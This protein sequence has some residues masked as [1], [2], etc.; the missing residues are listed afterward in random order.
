MSETTR[1]GSVNRKTSN[2]RD[3]S[4]DR[5]LREKVRE[6]KARGNTYGKR[7]SPPVMVRGDIGGP[8]LPLRKTTKSRAKRRFDLILNVPGAEMRLPALPQVSIDMRLLSAFLVAVL[9]LLIY[10]LWNSPSFHVEGA[11]IV[12]LQRL[13]SRDVNAIMNLE[14]ESIFVIDPHLVEQK[15]REAFPEFAEVKVDVGLPA[16]VD[17]AIV[18]RLPILTWRQDGRTV[19][20]DANGI[21]FPQ[22]D[23]AGATP[24]VVVE[25]F[26]SPPVLHKE[27]K[28]DGSPVRFIPVEMVSA[29]LSMSAQAPDQT[30]VVYDT[31]HGLGWKDARGWEV[32][33]GDARD[34]E[35]KLRVYHAMLK[36]F[37]A[38]G[39]QPALISVEYVHRPY[40][41]MEK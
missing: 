13:N 31:T 18:E 8:P 35:M 3:Q 28:L 15:A 9:G 36:E 4:I 24:A 38:D 29:I 16:I 40:Y 22:R 21:A 1:Y 34:I 11:R 26:G 19:L 17:I 14:G 39:V 7:R 23:Q 41:R 25:A 10:Y 30:P 6:A 27:A 37:Q 2:R 5:R 32:Y 33:F 20:V 12:G